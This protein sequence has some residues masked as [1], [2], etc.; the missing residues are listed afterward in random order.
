MRRIFFILCLI[1]ICIAAKAQYSSENSFI[2][3][4]IVS[5]TKDKKGFY[6]KET[7]RMVDIVTDITENYAYDKKAQNLYVLTDN[8]NVVVTL[9]K[10]YAKIIKRNKDIPHLSGEAL[11]NEIEKRNKLLYDKF[12]ALN[13]ER[14]QQITDSINKA[15]Q[16]SI[17]EVNRL[18]AI[19]AAQK[20]AREDYISNHKSHEV[21]LGQ[22][23][24]RCDICD[25]D[26]N[27]DDVVYTIG[28][29][30]DTIYY[31]TINTGDLDLSYVELHESK[32]PE[33]LY[34]DHNFMYHYEVYK[35]SLTNDSFDYKKFVYI[36]GYKY[37]EDYL[38]R[39]KKAAPYGYINEWSWNDEYSMVTFN[40]RY[41]N[42]NA[43]IIK[44]ITVY[45]RITN[46][47]D[48]VRCTG[49][50]KGTGP[51]K[52]GETASWNWDSSSYF[53]AGDSS[54]MNI[55][56]IVLTYMNG[57]KQIVSG[58]YLRFN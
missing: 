13:H 55:T 27:T 42:T 28:I 45:F 44:Y 56:K 47:V 57:T 18:N 54:N 46:D 39:L 17:D 4:E 38:A 29:K 48:D 50:F 25:N 2:R 7:N 33:A 11:D 14:E 26:I 6:V 19:M 24:I 37:Y 43:K 9:T 49:Y 3:K 1:I 58:K 8:S 51:L 53:T 10:D 16:D 35:D 5:Y 52:E 22:N 36:E 32:I 34:S 20:K 23:S 41:T 30:N 15:I 31:A 40:I 21:P 12:T